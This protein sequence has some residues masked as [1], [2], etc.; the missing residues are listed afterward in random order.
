PKHTQTPSGNRPPPTSTTTTAATAA[1][2]TRHSRTSSSVSSSTPTTTTTA[3]TTTTTAAARPPPPTSH[4]HTASSAS[5]S[6]GTAPAPSRKSFLPQRHLTSRRSPER[7]VPVTPLLPP[8]PKAQVAPDMAPTTATTTTLL[9][10]PARDASVVRPNNT[11]PSRRRR[12]S[13]RSSPARRGTLGGAGAGAGAGAA[14]KAQSVASNEGSR[15]LAHQQQQASSTERSNTGQ[16]RAAA[17]AA[18]QVP[19]ATRLDRS[20]SLRQTAPARV[21]STAARHTRNRSQVLVGTG[22]QAGGGGA[23]KNA[24]AESASRAAKPSFNMYQQH[25]SPK[26]SA[27]KAAVGSVSTVAAGDSNVMQ[28]LPPHIPPL[29][30]ELLQL[31]LLHAEGLQAKRKWEASMDAKCRELHSSVVKTY[32]SV[33]ATE[34]AVQRDR[35]VAALEQFAGD[36]HACNGRYD[37]A[38]QIQMLS[39]VIQE[40]SDLTQSRDGRYNVVIQEF[41]EWS[42]HVNEVKQNRMR[43]TGELQ[44]IDPL[45]DGWRNDV[46][47]LSA[48]LELCSRELDCVEI[49]TATTTQGDDRSGY[50]ASALAR[51][52]TGHRELIR[53][54]IDELDVIAKIESEVTMMERSWVTRTV[55]SLRIDIAPGQDGDMRIPA[56][57]KT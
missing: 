40:V 5:V 46:A 9:P 27:P 43:K 1:A 36:V 39:R 56:W 17:A 26:K 18:T 54:M 2:A 25:Y 6:G 33:L 13:L 49:R 15:S 23:A 53:S 42:A 28:A 50:H 14:V 48:K 52:V 45:R 10:P 29:Q 44:F 31:L 51:A 7:T 38:T 24:P 55:D 34:R 16:A 32:Q 22:Q 4:A 47:A 19:P 41:E 35:N 20:A 30:V 11:S 57:K 3:I 8:P 21:A 12:D 37:F